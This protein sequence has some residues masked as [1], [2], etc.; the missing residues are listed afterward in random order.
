MIWPIALGGSGIVPTGAADVPLGEAVTIPV[1]TII[2]AADV[3]GLEVQLVVKLKAAATASG[4]TVALARVRLDDVLD[5]LEGTRVQQAQLAWAVRT[6]GWVK[7]EKA[8]PTIRMIGR[9]QGGTAGGILGATLLCR[10]AR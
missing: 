8:H 7:L 6:S 10:E 3:D 5:L 2:Q 1:D 9:S 4:V